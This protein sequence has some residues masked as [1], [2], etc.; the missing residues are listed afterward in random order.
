MA[1]SSSTL[2][3]LLFKKSAGKGSTVDAREFFEEPFNG[4]IAI[5]KDQVWTQSDLIPA[6][7]PVLAPDAISGVIQYK[8]D[9]VLT[10]VAGA[11]GAFQS[12]DLKD[13]IPFNFD[14]AGS[15]NYVIKNSSNV[16]IPFGLGDWLVDGDTGTLTFYGSVPSGMPPKISFYKYIGTKGDFASAGSS[17]LTID[18]KGLIPLATSGNGADTGITI[19]NT[20]PENSHVDVKVNGISYIVGNGVTTTACHFEDPLVPGV[21]RFY[22]GLNRIVA[23]DKL[24]WNGV[25]AEFDLDIVDSVSLYYSE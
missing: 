20:P 17:I 16:P 9:V 22:S 4:N 10:A 11:P 21:A 19:S 12:N 14:P 23:G 15:Y 25:N 18:D 13:V 7:A 1:I 5:F 24:I 8:E 3:R 2:A 6:T